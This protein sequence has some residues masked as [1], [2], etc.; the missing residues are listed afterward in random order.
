MAAAAAGMA[1][2]ASPAVMSARRQDT[3]ATATGDISV[4]PGPGTLTASPATEISF[5]GITADVLG[6]VK[7]VGS[8]TGGHTGI[9][10]PHGDGNG[11][12]FLPDASFVPGEVVTVTAEVPLTA[13]GALTFGVVR[14]LGPVRTAADREDESPPATPR[15]FQSRPDLHPPKMEITTPATGTA[16]GLVFVTT[17]VP[18]GQNGLTI[19]DNEGELI[20]YGVAGLPTDMQFDL[21]VQQYQGQPVLTWAEAAMTVGYGFGHYIIADTSYQTIAEFGVGNGFPGG[22]VHE[23]LLTSRDTALIGIYHPV[24]WDLSAVG[25]SIYGKVVD[26]VVQEIEI[27]TG[28][29]LFEWHSLDHI[30]IDEAQNHYDGTSDNPYDYF[31]LNSVGET[32]DGALVISARHTFAIYKLDRQ[33]G[34]VIWRLNGTNSDFEMG[35][36]TPFAWQH[37]ARIHQNGELTLFDNA[38]SDQKLEGTVW[39]KGMALTLDEDAMT[40]TLA[41]EIV[42]PTHILSTSQGNAQRLPNDNMFVGWGSAPVFSEF[43]NDG[44]LI[45]NGRFPTNCNSYRAYR[46]P[47]SGQP[48]DPPDF[49]VRVIGSGAIVYASWNGATDVAHWRVIAGPTPEEMEIVGGAERAGFETSIRVGTV[50]EWYS[51][52]ALDAAGNVIDTAIAIQPGA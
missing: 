13:D 45:F 41:Q 2:L 34:A 37:D 9:I 52:Q 16:E 6:A 3:G 10:E 43:S 50:E 38:E 15:R 7:V 51:V 31:H 12:S 22:D 35:P 33:T 30:A 23:L 5:R 18:E 17:K 20:W 29:V 47:W 11:A 19:L 24:E 39:S 8:A 21:R 46:F 44:E 28:R 32:P 14:P 36:G 1:T 40:A 49:A 42:H 26:C 25:G 27:E 4:F 48:A